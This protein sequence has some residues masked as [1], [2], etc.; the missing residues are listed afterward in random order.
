M[1]DSMA[2]DPNIV[3]LLKNNYDFINLIRI[4][5]QNATAEEYSNI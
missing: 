1:A 3:L 4:D 2:L 5:A